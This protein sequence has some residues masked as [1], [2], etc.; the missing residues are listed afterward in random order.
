MVLLACTGAAFGQAPLRFDV[1]SVKA[2]EGARVQIQPNRSGG[3][4]TWPT[5]LLFIVSFAF[6]VPE[7]RIS[8]LP[9][10][11]E[12]Y[13]IDATTSAQATADEVQRM[14]QS[15]LADRFRMASHWTT[16]EMDGHDLTV[17]KGG[18]KMVEAHDGDPP[19]P[20]P[21]MLRRYNAEDLKAMDGLLIF[22]VPE[23]GVT[24]MAGRKV[25]MARL[26]EGLEKVLQAPVADRTGLA[27][28]YYFACEFVRP[29]GPEDANAGS[30]SAA[31]QS[32]GLRLEKRRTAVGVLVV[33]SIEKMPTE[34]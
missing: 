31:V 25:G 14:F 34:N 10:G 19:G 23:P 21:P 3:R 29:G 5:N 17:G 16:R 27:G 15:L 1:A 33:D 24:S 9:Q 32:L 13:V 26:A 6:Q 11:S 18:P 20:A 4:L 22:D 2:V 28:N 30:L 7:W 12:A 8:G